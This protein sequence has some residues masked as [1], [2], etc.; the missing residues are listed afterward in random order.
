MER[1][2]FQSHSFSFCAK[3][4]TK[5]TTALPQIFCLDCQMNILVETNIRSDTGKIMTVT[6]SKSKMKKSEKYRCHYCDKLFQ[7]VS[8]LNVHIRTHTGE[9]P[10]PCQLCHKAFSQS[11]SLKTHTQISHSAEKSFQCEYCGKK[12]A[13]RNYLRC[14]YRTHTKER[15][16]SCEHC[17]KAYTQQSSLATHVKVHH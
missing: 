1:R 8:F 12:F 11:S 17:G 4:G 6:E 15:P 10:Y 7:N 5:F 16:Y 9:K 2:P 3:C 13:I 14:H